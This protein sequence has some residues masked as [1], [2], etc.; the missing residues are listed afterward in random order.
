MNLKFLS[1][2]S[3]L[4]ISGSLFSG[5]REVKNKNGKV[6]KEVTYSKA[7]VLADD[8]NFFWE[9]SSDLLESD[10]VEVNCL[11]PVRLQNTL[12]VAVKNYCDDSCN[13]LPVEP[14]TSGWKK[15]CD[16]LKSFK[17]LKVLLLRIKL[18][19]LS[20]ASVEYFFETI[21][22]LPNK[23]ELIFIGVNRE[24]E[25]KIEKRLKS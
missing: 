12:V 19:L 5:F 4:L 21:E 14:L 24:F 23:T 10:F 7:C 17:N 25:Q 13:N 22:A 9:V 11:D 1:V 16:T 6:L 20:D 8:D 2:V 15:I 3:V 18:N